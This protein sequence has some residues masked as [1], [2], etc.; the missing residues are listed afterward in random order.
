MTR[1]TAVPRRALLASVPMLLAASV[2]ARA[3]IHL[4]LSQPNIVPL[5]IAIPPFVG[6]Q[7]NDQQ[8]GRD[9]AGVISADLERAELAAHRAYHRGRDLQARHRRGR[10]FRYQGGLHLRERSYDE[11]DQAPRHHGP[12]WCQS[13]LSHGRPRAGA[14]A[15]LLTDPAGDHLPLLRER[16]A[17][18]LSL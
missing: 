6:G 11:A 12:G 9:I 14:D 4:E 5:P 7:P 13:S 17:A 1:N 10:L 3:A 16:H 15:A 18:R 8:V 2:A